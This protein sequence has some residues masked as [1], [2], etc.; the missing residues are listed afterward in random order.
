EAK[1]EFYKR[2][3]DAGGY[4]TWDDKTGEGTDHRSQEE[5][6]RILGPLS[7]SDNQ[8]GRGDDQ[9]IMTDEQLLG[10]SRTIRRHIEAASRRSLRMLTYDILAKP[11]NWKKKFFRDRA[12]DGVRDLEERLAQSTDA[13]EH[14]KLSD[15][16][17]VKREKYSRL[18]EKYEKRLDKV[19]GRREQIKN[20][21]VDKHKDAV[22]AQKLAKAREAARKALIQSGVKEPE[23]E[24]RLNQMRPEIRKQLWDVALKAEAS[25]RLESLAENRHHRSELNTPRLEEDLSK[26]LQAGDRERKVLANAE[27]EVK[28]WSDVDRRARQ[29]ME[30]SRAAFNRASEEDPKR[31]VL[32]SRANT[33]RLSY[34]YAHNVRLPQATEMRDRIKGEVEELEHSYGQ[35]K[36]NTEEERVKLEENEAEMAH[37]RDRARYYD[38]RLKRLIQNRETTK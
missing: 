32:M 20:I 16:L 33:A 12:R 13:G 11:R 30:V 3:M 23:V 29:A 1:V 7:T 24:Q 2:A 35:A 10:S 34:E 15:K 27:R 5:S 4:K 6:E 21:Y 28:L 14:R 26:L 38:Q 25:K 18:D 36:I 17:T 37:S 9:Y 19:D 8:W 31:P 22:K